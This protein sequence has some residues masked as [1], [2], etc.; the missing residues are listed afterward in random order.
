M[1]TA[2]ICCDGDDDYRRRPEE[3]CNPVLSWSSRLVLLAEG[4]LSTNVVVVA[5]VAVTVAQPNFRLP[6]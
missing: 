1:K 3:R 6:K 2:D 4:S 5:V